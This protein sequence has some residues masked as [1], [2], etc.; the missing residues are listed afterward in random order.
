MAAGYP[1]GVGD[2]LLLVQHFA[3]FYIYLG[4]LLW[5]I[6][7]VPY[8]R[9]KWVKRDPIN[10]TLMCARDSLTVI[11]SKTA[12]VILTLQQKIEIILPY[13]KRVFYV[14][15]LFVNVSDSHL[16]FFV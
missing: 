9:T 13:N 15:E 12:V 16:A 1:E 10:K 2:V 11:I 5:I 3:R 14:T 6:C 7:R 8:D 4:F